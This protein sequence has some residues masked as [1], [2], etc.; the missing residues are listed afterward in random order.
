V[1]SREKFGRNPYPTT[2]RGRGGEGELSHNAPVRFG[3]SG[4]IELEIAPPFPR[5]SRPGIVLRD[6]SSIKNQ[7]SSP[8]EFQTRATRESNIIGG[9]RVQQ[10]IDL[11]SALM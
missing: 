5:L 11:I 1:Y 8:Y 6:P 2:H 4:R 3:N 9:T 7:S 10:S